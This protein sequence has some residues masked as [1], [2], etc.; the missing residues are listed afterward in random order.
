MQLKWHNTN[1]KQVSEEMIPSGPG[2]GHAGRARAAGARKQ[3]VRGRAER[4]SRGTGRRA[5]PAPL[6]SPYSSRSPCGRRCRRSSRC[7]AAAP[8][9]APTAAP[10][11]RRGGRARAAACPRLR[12]LRMR[13]RAGRGPHLRDASGL[14]APRLARSTI[15]RRL[16]RGGAG[17]AA[18]ALSW[19]RYLR[20]A[21]S[22]GSRVW[23]RVGAHS[24]AAACRLGNAAPRARPG[25]RPGRPGRAGAPSSTWQ[26]ARVSTPAASRS[27]SPQPV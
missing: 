12:A 20:R 3:H 9:R 19:G 10:W 17:D 18:L 22:R 25:A 15:H 23:S 4:W 27:A 1:T 26:P 14:P 11:A 2:L 5:P 6:G 16:A 7:A 24:V 13:P 21:A 8:A